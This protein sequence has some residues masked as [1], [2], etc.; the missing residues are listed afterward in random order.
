MEQPLVSI[1]LTLYEISIDYLNKCIDSLLKQ[2]Y[3]NIE[4][5][6]VDD[7]SPIT[8]YS[9]LTSLS[10]KIKLYRNETNLK[11][12]KTLAKCFELA[13]GKYIV[14]VGPDDY[15]APTLIEKEVKILENNPKVGT[16]C[17]NIKK[18]ENNN[19]I[20]FRPKTWNITKILQGELKGTGYDGGMMFRSSLLPFISVNLEHKVCIDFDLQLQLL[21]QMPIKT[22][23]EP[24]YFYRINKKC[25]SS[26]VLGK[27]REIIMNEI[28]DRHR[29]KLNITY[30]PKPI[31][32]KPKN[33]KV[34]KK[35][36]FF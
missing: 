33:K 30:I 27:A 11:M 13:R 36:E 32:H 29:K 20:I 15:I 3:D 7:C 8:D 19:K 1:V 9:Y 24:L 16:V 18:F 21:E 22:L 23:A 6:I 5:I 10:P 34:V 31:V 14:R 2:S 4:I 25:I 28:L 17:C 26:S 12:N 35:R